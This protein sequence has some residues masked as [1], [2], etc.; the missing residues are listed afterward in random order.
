LEFCNTTLERQKCSMERTSIFTIKKLS[1][2]DEHMKNNIKFFADGLIKGLVIFLTVTVSTTSYSNEN[3]P[4][5]LVVTKLHEKLL[6][7][8]QNGETLGH[9]VIIEELSNIIPSG[10]NLHLISQVVL[11]RHW[12]KLNEAEKK[13]FISVY[14]QLVI[15][16]YASTFN[17]YDGESFLYVSTEN[18]NRGRKMV[19]TELHSANGEVV[20][21]NYLMSQDNN[22][23]MI[24]SVIANGAND[25]SIKRGEYA[26]VIKLNGYDALLNLINKKLTKINNEE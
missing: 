13:N 9:Q 17:E 5:V 12:A 24:I 15:E 6:Y 4:E 25:I 14:T 18:L 21:L 8:M 19:N 7:T 26:D 11:G 3:A 1:L 2:S 23:W 20:T 22:K 10:F 16:T